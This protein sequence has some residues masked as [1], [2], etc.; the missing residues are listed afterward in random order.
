MVEL[1]RVCAVEVLRMEKE[2]SSIYREKGLETD[3][4]HDLGTSNE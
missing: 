2:N 1:S 3:E 4:M